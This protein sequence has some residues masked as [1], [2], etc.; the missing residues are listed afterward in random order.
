[1]SYLADAYDLGVPR[2]WTDTIETHRREV[3]EAVLDTTAALVAE[4]G[5]LSVTM[6]RIA[7]ETG[8]GRATL[9]KYFPDVESILTA[10]HQRQIA[11]HLACLA[12]IR[13]RE[14]D[15]TKRLY[16]VLT[17]YA[18]IRHEAHRHHDTEFA[19]LM[20]QHEHLAHGERQLR[21]MIGSLL[22][23][24][25]VSGAIRQDVPID[26]LASYCLHAL[27]TATKLP[28]K[29]SVRRLVAVTLTG[30]RPIR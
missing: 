12:E 19:S 14:R 8:I 24:A 16:A 23:D 7:E 5:L 27:A 30:L 15:P 26:E 4:S 18:L 17:A 2:L 10:W 6:S 9:Y 11:S 22:A 21:D 25:A 29:A 1:M 13:D 3:R 20:H 28:S